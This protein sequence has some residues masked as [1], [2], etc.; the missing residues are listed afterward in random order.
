MIRCCKQQCC[1]CGGGEGGEG[2]EGVVLQ[3]IPLSWF[4][5]DV[6]IREGARAKREGTFREPLRT[7]GGD[8][9]ADPS[10]TISCCQHTHTHTHESPLAPNTSATDSK[11]WLTRTRKQHS[12]LFHE[13]LLHR[14]SENKKRNLGSKLAWT[15]NRIPGTNWMSNTSWMRFSECLLAHFLV[16]VWLYLWPWPR[17]SRTNAH[18][19]IHL[20][21][22][23]QFSDPIKT[24]HFLNA[25]PLIIIIF[26]IV[27]SIQSS[28]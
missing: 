23:T 28:Y 15:R 9:T 16:P 11:A 22:F 2:G 25:T 20:H 26:R 21:S 14:N 3:N 1:W 8:T 19:R 4:E 6:R 13:M 5:E 27:I 17:V 7:D 10:L 18:N 24:R 12:L